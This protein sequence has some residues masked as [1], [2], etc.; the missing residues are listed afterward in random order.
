MRSDACVCPLPA[1]AVPMPGESLRSLIRRTS[2]A[3]GYETQG[4]LYAH[5]SE[6]G[7][8]PRQ[9][10]ELGPGPA[11]EYFANL[12][13]LP[14]EILIPLTVHHH[15]PSLM[16]V[17]SGRQAPT[18]CDP[19][20]ASRY[21]ASYSTVC[22]YCLNT[23]DIP[24]ERLLWQFRPAPVCV[25]HGCLLVRRCFQCNQPF[26]PG[27]LDV[28]RCACA[29]RLGDACAAPVTSSGVELATKVHQI[30][31]GQL[32]PDS[33]TPPSVWFWWIG[34]LVVAVS[35]MPAWL[36]DVAD[37]L[38]VHPDTHPEEAAWL[39]ATEIIINWPRRME[40]FL[41]AFLRRDKR[42]TTPVGMGTRF[43]GLCR[44]AYDL[45]E[46]GYPA[47]ADA[48]R[49]YLLERYDGGSLGT[50]QRLLSKLEHRVAFL[51]R[52]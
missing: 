9:P 4:L 22:P 43:W 48:M 19:V 7:P 27:R 16:L 33:K 14:A 39:T 29:A 15:A 37:R 6:Q 3:M 41:E 45:E 13:R 25:E 24:H 32:A 34:R 1:R 28:S 8:I 40:T 52:T 35:K 31:L 42:R 46:L 49:H 5:L 36:S 44:H 17:P 51:K 30:L 20:T 38:G 50:N 10:N 2:Q 26:R 12:L 18:L 21:F 47:P 23:D 11:L